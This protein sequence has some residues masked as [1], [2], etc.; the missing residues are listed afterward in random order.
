MSQFGPEAWKM[1][2]NQLVQMLESAQKQLSNLRLVT[3]QPHGQTPSV[4]YNF[5][6]VPGLI[7]SVSADF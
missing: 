4:Y 1:Y 7:R 5:P 3:L 2:N 6:A